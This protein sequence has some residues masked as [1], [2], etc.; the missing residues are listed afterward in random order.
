MGCRE[1]ARVVAGFVYQDRVVANTV[2][3]GGSMMS[4]KTRRNLRVVF[5]LAMTAFA[6]LFVALGL[7]GCEGDSKSTT[8]NEAPESV[9]NVP[10]NGAGIVTSLDVTG[11]NNTTLIYVRT[12]PGVIQVIEVDIHG[13]SNVVGV[14]Y[15]QPTPPEPE[16]P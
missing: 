8:V 14:I 9:I 7:S 2:V 1:Q 10:T 15:E 13:N 12:T 11:D 4:G 6:L 3:K 5:V 16:A